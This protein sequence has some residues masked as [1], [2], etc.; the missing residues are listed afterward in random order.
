MSWLIYTDGASKG[1][2]GVGG[3]AAV[4]QNEEKV[5]ELGARVEQATNNQM[6]LTAAVEAL[7]CV[8]EGDHA[9]L[10]TD[11]TYLRKGITLW[12]T[13]W[14][15]TGWKTSTKEPVKNQTLW[16]AL[17]ELTSKRD[18]TWHYVKAHVGFVGNERADEIA[19]NFASGKDV[20][21]YQGSRANYPRNL[22]EQLEGVATPRVKKNR[23]N[24]PPYSYVSKVNGVIQTHASWSECEA[25]VKGK[26][27]ARFKKVYSVEEERALKQTWASLS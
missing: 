20:E 21:L 11:S 2:P 27:G 24:R 6:E 18:I 4:L 13:L 14:K 15:Q 9:D 7:K 17:D 22:T 8:P 3:F 26:S 19:S 1:N 10:H 5:L 12:L 25:R 16:Q 23:D